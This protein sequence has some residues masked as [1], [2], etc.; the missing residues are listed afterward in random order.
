MVISPLVA[1]MKDQVDSCTAKGL[2]AAYVSIL[3]LVNENMNQ[4]GLEGRYQLVFLSPEALFFSR[5]GKKC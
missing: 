2:S 5:G 4:R 3:N 1:L